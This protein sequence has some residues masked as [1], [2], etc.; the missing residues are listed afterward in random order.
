[1]TAAGTSSSTSC[2]T[3]VGTT[4]QLRDFKRAAAEET[5]PEKGIAAQPF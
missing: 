2:P 4:I 1:V 3:E 5:E